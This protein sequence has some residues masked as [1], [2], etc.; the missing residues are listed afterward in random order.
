M[1]CAAR[2]WELHVM[3]A[4]ARGAHPCLSSAGSNLVARSANVSVSV[5]GMCQHRGMMRHA[6]LVLR[7]GD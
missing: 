2:A 4:C 3:R 6:W 7:A 5:H 1:R